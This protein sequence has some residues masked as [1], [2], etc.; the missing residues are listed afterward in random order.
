[1]S[2]FA[3]TLVILW[4]TIESYGI[5][6]A[7]LFAAEDI[8]VKL[9]IDPGVRVPFVKIDR[10][11]AKTAKLTGD[12]AFGLR[13]ASVYVPSQLGALGYAWQASLTLRKACSRL[14]RFGRVV[15]DKAIVRVE[16]KDGCMVVTLKLDVPSECE[17]VR[18]DST[19]S[20]VTMMCR[21]VSGDFFRLQAVNFKHPEPRDI[22]PYFE[23]FGCQLNFDQDENQLLIPLSL[24]DE[25]LAGANPELAMLNDQ[26]V[27]RRLA[28]LDRND[29]V[30]RVQSELLDQ[31]PNG[32]VSDD[33]VA[34]SMYM[35]VRTLHR[36]LT[37]ADSNFR[38]LLV[39]T[40]RNLAEQYIMDNSLTLTEISLLLGFS[41]PSSFSRAYKS[42]T[43]TAPSEA[44]QA[45]L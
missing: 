33:S 21:L 30:A 43:G 19:L 9:P 26:V 1:M 7:P 5:D 10:I 34:A 13:A 15:N 20:M 12:E 37:N 44:R 45:R 28:L 36:K 16:D 3:P 35:S 6:P 4:R 22:K 25:V 11:R 14:Q 18:D 42:W 27:T 23:Y 29:I 31:L 41:E 38:T 39:E 40:R 2:V 32:N 17:A 24:A 8:K